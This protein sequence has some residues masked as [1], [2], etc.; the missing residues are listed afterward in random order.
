MFIRGKNATNPV[1]LYLH[2]GVPEYLLTEHYPI[3]YFA[4]RARLPR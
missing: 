1:L 4:M 3:T 2:G